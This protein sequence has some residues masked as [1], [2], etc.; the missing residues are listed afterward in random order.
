MAEF[1]A[2]EKCVRR[3]TTRI[4]ELGERIGGMFVGISR[5]RKQ[6]FDLADD[7]DGGTHPL[8]ISFAPPLSD[9]CDLDRIQKRKLEQ[10]ADEAV[11]RV[12][13]VF[14]LCK[15]ANRTRGRYSIAMEFGY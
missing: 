7:I 14:D 6:R 4:S 2:F 8:T 15:L 12:D 13:P 1:D 3:R 11:M 10:M 9:E 5:Q